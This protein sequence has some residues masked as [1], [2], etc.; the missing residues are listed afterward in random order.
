MIRHYRQCSYWVD[1]GAS[2]YSRAICRR[3]CYVIVVRNLPP[4][5]PCLRRC[6]RF[7]INDQEFVMSQEFVIVDFLSR[8]Q[9]LLLQIFFIDS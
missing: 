8:T 5:Q 4:K 7:T 3:D 6:F 9:S 1:K 2:M